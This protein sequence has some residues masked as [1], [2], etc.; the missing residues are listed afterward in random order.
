MMSARSGQGQGAG[1]TGR[2]DFRSLER[3]AMARG[4]V[5]A[6]RRKRRGGDDDVVLA[7]YPA[8]RADI[9]CRY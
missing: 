8:E 1:Q 2:G 4:T 9:R 3:E 6:C 5:P 7:E